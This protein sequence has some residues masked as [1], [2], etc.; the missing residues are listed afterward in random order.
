M[1]WEFLRHPT[2]VAKLAALAIGDCPATLL[3]A[4]LR[5][6]VDYIADDAA[7]LGLRYDLASWRLRWAGAEAHELRGDLRE[8]VRLSIG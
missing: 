4:L 2:V 3:R 7:H 8:R 6:A 1:A 5:T